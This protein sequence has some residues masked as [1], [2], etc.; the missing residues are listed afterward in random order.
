MSANMKLDRTARAAPERKRAPVPVRTVDQDGSF[1]GYA[2]LFGVVDLG[3]D[4]VANGAFRR[5]LASRKPSAVRMLYQH[6]PDEPIGVWDVVREDAT[7]LFVSGR[8]TSDS[9]RGR[10]VLS[11]LRSGAVD[12]LSIGFRTDRSRTDRK[13]SI[14]TILEADLWEVSIVTFP[15]L[16]AARVSTVKSAPAAAIPNV[17]TFEQWLMR[18]AGLTRSQARTII[19]KGF[20]HLL[21]T[22]DA[23]GFNGTHDAAGENA[24]QASLRRATERLQTARMEHS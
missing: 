16:P 20:T 6:A 24:L 14:R 2:S 10:E 1:S 13:T 15:M 22:Q 21:G 4:R 7:G 19:T 9:A 3:K 23:A 12:G 17:R 8:I 11:L 18:G 5:C